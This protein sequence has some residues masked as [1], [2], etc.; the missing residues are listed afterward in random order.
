MPQAVTS[1]AMIQPPMA[2]ATSPGSANRARR[3]CGALKAVV[4]C[5]VL[6]APSAESKERSETRPRW[7]VLTH[8]WIAM[9]RGGAPDHAWS[10]DGANSFVP[11]TAPIMKNVGEG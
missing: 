2:S 3:L 8:G 1:P 9:V 7:K 11:I 6:D 4:G 5:P 10:L